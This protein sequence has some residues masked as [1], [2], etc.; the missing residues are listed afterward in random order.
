MEP[1]RQR[2]PGEIVFSALMLIISLVLF[3]NAYRI[4]GFAAKSSPGSFP[5]AATA[6]MVVASLVSLAKSFAAP[7]G[8]N[9][10]RAFRHRVIPNIVIVFAGLILLYGIAL[11]SI[12]FV[13]T[14]LAFLFAGMLLLYRRGPGPALFWAVVSVIIVYVIFRLV[15]QV[16]LPEGIIPERRLLADIGT[17]IKGVLGR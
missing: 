10:W 15:F 16:V 8:D 17:L 1:K 6:V 12:G 11:E 14:S 3:W 13:L 2:L 4:S 9:G 5:L 7:T